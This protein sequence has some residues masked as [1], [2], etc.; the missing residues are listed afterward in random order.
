MKY[1]PPYQTNMKCYDVRQSY[2]IRR[3]EHF[4]HCLIIIPLVSLSSI[5]KYYSHYWKYQ[6]FSRNSL[7]FIPQ[8][9]SQ[10]ISY[11]LNI[12]IITQ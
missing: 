4:I 8:P 9:V 12:N 1:D 7:N 3:T 6:Q 5:I 2:T 11:I 10:S